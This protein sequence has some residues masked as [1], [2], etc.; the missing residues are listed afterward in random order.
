MN[1]AGSAARAVSAGNDDQA[2]WQASTQV[3]EERLDWVVIWLA[4]KGEHR[5]GQLFGHAGHGGY[6]CHSRR[7][8][9]LHGRYPAGD[10]PPVETPCPR[11]PPIPASRYPPIGGIAMPACLGPSMEPL[12]STPAVRLATSD[13]EPVPAFR[14]DP[15][16]P[17]SHVPWDARS[18]GGR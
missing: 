18:G 13:G 1:K 5:S 6:W 11:L 9:H 8:G 7:F 15:D 3:R 12:P 10:R 17:S 4:R 16:R 2:R 14:A